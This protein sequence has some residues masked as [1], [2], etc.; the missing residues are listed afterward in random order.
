[1][2]FY[3]QGTVLLVWN[4]NYSV[5]Y[6]WFTL[7]PGPFPRQLC[8]LPT[9]TFNFRALG[10]RNWP[11]CLC[12]FV[13]WQTCLYFRMKKGTITWLRHWLWKDQGGATS[14]GFYKYRGTE[15]KTSH[16]YVGTRSI[17]FFFLPLLKSN[18]IVVILSQ[19]SYK[20]STRHHLVYG[21][22]VFQ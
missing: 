13:T 3:A 15:L 6:V 18:F 5:W 10:P 19:G 1:M 22:E 21:K 11:V 16:V 12:R 14:P 9:H 4:N 2:T 20:S 17:Y 7:N 8:G